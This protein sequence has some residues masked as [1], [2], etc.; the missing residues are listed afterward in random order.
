MAANLSCDKYRLY[1]RLR[2]RNLL[3]YSSKPLARFIRYQHF[4]KFNIVSASKTKHNVNVLHVLL[5]WDQFHLCQTGE[6]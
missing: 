4:L 1:Y 2:R 5:M 6:S 3:P